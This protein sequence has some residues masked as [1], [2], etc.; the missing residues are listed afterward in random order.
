[1]LIAPAYAVTAMR[2]PDLMRRMNK[3]TTLTTPALTAA[4]KAFRK[5]KK[6]KLAGDRQHAASEA[7]QQVA[8]PNRGDKDAQGGER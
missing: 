8:R 5:A 3:R 4:L 7:G 2:A 6:K 1:M